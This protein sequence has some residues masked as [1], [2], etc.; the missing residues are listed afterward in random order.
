MAKWLSKNCPKIIHKK[1]FI[2]EN[3]WT[4]SY[5]SVGSLCLI[6]RFTKLFTLSWASYCLFCLCRTY[7]AS[8]IISYLILC[9]PTGNQYKDYGS[10]RV[11]VRSCQGFS[12]AGV[13]SCPIPKGPRCDQMWD[14]CDHEFLL[15]VLPLSWKLNESITLAS[16]T[17]MMISSEMSAWLL[18]LQE[19]QRL[20]RRRPSLEMSVC[21]M[22]FL[23]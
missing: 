12:K 9:I 1:N 8:I 23:K 22:F 14:Q 16:W 11:C 3:L 20:W 17:D 6:W 2:K 5:L 18:G 10:C 19:I 15:L 13:L 4:W 7:M 21:W